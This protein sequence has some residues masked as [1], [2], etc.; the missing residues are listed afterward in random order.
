MTFSHPLAGLLLLSGLLFSNVATAQDPDPPFSGLDT[1]AT[2]EWWKRAD[3]P[4]INLRVDRD[5]VIA[6]GAYTV[7][8]GTLK[9]SAQ[10]YPLY[11]DEDRQVRLEVLRGGEWEMIGQEEVNPLGWSALFRVPDWDGTTTVP[12]RM[13]HGDGAVFS[14]S[15]RALPGPEEEVVV[16]AFSCNSNQDRGGRE[17]YVHNVAA[18]D[19]D[20][21]FFA[22]DQ[23]YDHTEHTAA[24]L[25]FGLQFRETFRHRP[26]VSIPDDHDIGQGNL[27]GEGGKASRVKA[28]NDGGYYYHPEYV[29]MVERCQTAHLPDPYDP[30]PVGQGIGVYYTSYRLGGVDFAIIEDR[31]FKSGPAGKIPQL[32]PRP[33][34]INDPSYDPASIDLP[35]LELLGQRQ[36]DFLDQWAEDRAGNPM[37]AVLSATGFC[38]GAHL[39]GSKSN[40]L[41]ADL[42]SNGWPQSGRNAALRAIRDAQAVHIAGD[43]H[44]ATVIHHGIDEFRDGPWAFVVPA[45]VNDYYSRWW[46]PAGER[47][48]DNPVQGSPLPWTGDYRDGFGNPISMVAYAN[49]ENVSAGAGFG[50]IYFRPTSREVTFACWPREVDVTDEAAR[51]FPGW[52]VTVLPEE[53]GR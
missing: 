35:G 16:A 39:H 18:L 2:G 31:K 25:K 21:M 22:G 13:R 8:N 32:G 6:F 36:L 46:W 26:M 45:S 47:A 12:Y 33:D 51:Q 7:A 20:L 4:I 5:S 44:L 28:G 3:N 30:T 49:P 23:S 37:K 19:P 9:L 27:W 50:V 29:K 34:H 38:G 41:H 24:W 53:S 52:P 10:F 11:P 17:Q 40:R 42:D 1:L 43:Q 48:G 15:I 14:G